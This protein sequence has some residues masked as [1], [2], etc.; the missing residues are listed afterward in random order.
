MYIMDY[1]HTRTHLGALCRDHECTTS[2]DFL[3]PLTHCIPMVGF[4]AS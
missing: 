1:V 2:P 4:D 3:S